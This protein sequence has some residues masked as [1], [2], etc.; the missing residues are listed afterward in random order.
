[1]FDPHYDPAALTERGQQLCSWCPVYRRKPV[2][3]ELFLWPGFPKEIWEQVAEGQCGGATDK[4]EGVY[5]IGGWSA[6]H[7]PLS[8]IDSSDL[9]GRPDLL[10]EK[11]ITK[12][13]VLI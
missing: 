12:N 13:K 7:L 2:K 10:A 11:T 4:D 1:M 9:I 6:S 5:W 3:I 8:A